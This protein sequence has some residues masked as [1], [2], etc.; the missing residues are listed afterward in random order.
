M[1]KKAILLVT[2]IIALGML[3]MTPIVSNT[4]YLA[5]NQEYFIPTES[6]IFSFH[7]TMMNEWSGDWWLYG[8]DLN[9]YY[10]LN[11]EDHHP[12]YYKIPKD[13]NIENFDQYDYKTWNVSDL[14]N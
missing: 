10:A 6:N 9:F 2:S 1:N 11:Q 3:I 14:I 8:Q 13:H 7:A 12:K 5:T 4:R